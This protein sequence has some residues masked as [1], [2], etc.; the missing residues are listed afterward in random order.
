MVCIS[1]VGQTACFHAAFI[2]QSINQSKGLQWG[3]MN[4]RGFILVYG[5]SFCC[6]ITARKNRFLNLVVPRF[7]AFGSSVWSEQGEE[8]MTGMKKVFDFVGFFHKT[9]WSVEGVD[10]EETGLC[11]ERGY[12]HF[13]W[14]WLQNQVVLHPFRMFSMVHLQKL[15]RVMPNVLTFL[16]ITSM[17]L[18]LIFMSWNWICAHLF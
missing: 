3:R 11:D 8:R 15:V 6:L 18:L 10:S 2:N 1:S 17:W 16:I 9:V 13:L 7:Q 5:W 12:S 14:S 4:D